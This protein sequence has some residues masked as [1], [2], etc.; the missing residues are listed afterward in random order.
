MKNKFNWT[1]A[2]LGSLIIAGLTLIYNGI[3]SFINHSAFSFVLLLSSIAQS[4]V[5]GLGAFFLAFSISRQSFRRS[6]ILFITLSVVFFTLLNG[7]MFVIFFSLNNISVLYVV[8]I[9][10]ISAVEMLIASIS[11]VNIGG[12]RR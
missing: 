4:L 9:A 1:L 6:S 3:I 8:G 11:I 5:L 10:L 2:M 7:I 12:S